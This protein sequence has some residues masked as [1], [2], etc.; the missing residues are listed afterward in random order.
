MGHE[1]VPMAYAIGDHFTYLLN[2][3]IYIP[4]AGLPV[5]VLN[6]KFM[7][8]SALYTGQRRLLMEAVKP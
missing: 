8:Q 7:P 1:G 4:N 6:L 5:G 2:K 3:E